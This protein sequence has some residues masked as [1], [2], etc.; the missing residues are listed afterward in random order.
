MKGGCFSCRAH[1]SGLRGQDDFRSALATGKNLAAVQTISISELLDSQSLPRFRRLRAGRKNSLDGFWT[2][3]NNA[4]MKNPNRN[5]SIYFLARK[6]L[7]GRSSTGISRSHTLTLIGIALGV[8]ALITV[9]SVMN[10]F[11][12]DIRSRI[13][14]TLSE[15]RL[16]APGNEG[17]KDYQGIIS[18]LQAEGFA[19]APVV[20]TELLLRSEQASAPVVVFGIDPQQQKAVSPVL[21]HLPNEKFWHGVVAGEMQPE[22]FNAGGIALGS[23]LASELGLYLGDEVQL[24]SPIF[25]VPTP[26]GLLPKVH[27]LRVEAIFVAGM[28]EYDQSYCYIPLSVAQGFNSYHDQV[29]YI[30]IRSDNPQHSRRHL[31]QLAPLFKEYKL[32]DWSSFD[33]SLYGAIRFEKYLM[34]VI[35]LFMFIIA[36]FNLTGSLF[37]L[38]T[39]KKAELG[40]LKALGYEERELRRLFLYQAMMLC[41]LGIVMGA[42]LS[43]ILLLIQD[44]TGL[45][46]LEDIIV[47]PVKIQLSDYLLVI[48][49]S[50][51]LTWLSVLLPLQRL[52]KINAVELIR[53]NA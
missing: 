13:I 15:I 2:L 50:Y 1:E 19:A 46:K 27:Y 30:E 10:G 24:I 52:K 17:L 9:S 16:S 35:L 37:K 48:A 38:I 33:A 36:S 39:Q 47:L 34:F 32:E 49:V 12:E 29:D 44:Q 18:Q 31:R 21:N 43:T 41:T 40:L 11:R 14:G 4:G 53:H 7:A 20:R 28:P 22:A 42:I 51:I 23:A 5:A 45:V 26:F 6:Y 8:M 25:N 3:Q